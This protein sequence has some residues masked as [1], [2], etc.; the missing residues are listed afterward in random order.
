MCK[1]PDVTNFCTLG[2][3]W[4]E[5]SGSALCRLLGHWRARNSFGRSWGR[6]A[7]EW[8]RRTELK[9]EMHIMESSCTFSQLA[10]PPSLLS[11]V[12][13]GQPTGQCKKTLCFSLKNLAGTTYIFPMSFHASV[14]W[15]ITGSL[16][17]FLLRTISSARPL[18][19]NTGQET[20]L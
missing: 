18:E 8:V 6:A 5:A 3:S 4:R 13:L 11:Q 17:F 15:V 10:C 1:F 9:N 12:M 20:V 14:W 19:E 2:H 7:Q 16:D